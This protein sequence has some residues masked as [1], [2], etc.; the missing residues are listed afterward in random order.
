[1]KQHTLASAINA[2]LEFSTNARFSVG[3][4]TIEADDR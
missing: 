4:S 2:T 1:M 3:W